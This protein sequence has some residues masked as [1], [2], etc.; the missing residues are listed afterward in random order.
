MITYDTKI[1][2]TSLTLHVPIYIGLLV[3]W[4]VNVAPQMWNDIRVDVMTASM[5]VSTMKMVTK[6]K[7]ECN[8]KVG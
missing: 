1:I 3:G 8:V 4:A 6:M 5:K 2:A 7:T